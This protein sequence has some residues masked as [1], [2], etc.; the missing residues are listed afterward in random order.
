MKKNIFHISP[1][2]NFIDCMA[3]GLKVRFPNI[4]ELN[5]CIIFLPTK[6][7]KIRFENALIKKLQIGE[8]TLPKIFSLGEFSAKEINFL[9]QNNH[10]KIKLSDESLNFL[11]SDVN[12][13]ILLSK[14]ISRWKK[15]QGKEAENLNNLLELSD[16]LGNGQGF[17]GQ[18]VTK[19]FWLKKYRAKLLPPHISLLRVS[20]RRMR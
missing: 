7:S 11:V 9:N 15:Y 16:Q 8:E 10:H 19:L 12:R 6:K 5:K 14:L 2:S 13:S 17:L 20:M 3:Q 4:S 1:N 18:W